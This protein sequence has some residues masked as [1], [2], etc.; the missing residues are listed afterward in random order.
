MPVKSFDGIPV[1]PGLRPDPRAWMG[2]EQDRP[3]ELVADGHF[4][5]FDKARA[6]GRWTGGSWTKSDL[7]VVL[8]EV[9]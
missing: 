9:G 2:R 1:I 8:K 5:A 6:E 3:A 7:H 4:D